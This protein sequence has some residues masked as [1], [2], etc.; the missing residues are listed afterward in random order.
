VR[1]ERGAVVKLDFAGAPQQAAPWREAWASKE[2]PLATGLVLIAI[3]WLL[4]W[5]WETAQSMVA[6]WI[7]SETFAHGFLIV[8]IAAWIV[9]RERHTIAALNPRPNF[10]VLPLLAAAGFG[11]L[12][13]HVAGTGVLQ[14]FGL[15]IMIQLLA[16]TILGNQV[17]RALAFP[18]FFLLF[19][20]PFG[21]FLEPPLMDYTADFTAWAI[22]LTGI[23][24]FRDGRFL[25]LPSG[26]W[27]I[28]EACSGL[29]YL[30]AS[31][32]VG[33][34]YAYLT[35]RTAKRRVLF[36]VAS[37]I[38]PIVANWLR[39]FTVIMIG[40]FSGMKYAVG[41]D[42][43]IYGWFFFGVVIMLLFWIGSYWREDLAEHGT[44]PGAAAPALR[45]DSAPGA[46]LLA[47]LAAA[48]I[49]AV[50][51]AVA[52]R[53][54]GTGPYPPLNLQAP[55]PAGGWQPVDGRFTDWTPRI[56]N[57]RIQI[58]QTYAR[59]A[60]RAGIN[61]S[62][63]RNQNKESQLITSQNLTLRSTEANWA[64]SG[65]TRR[66]PVINNEEMPTIEAQLRSA[67]TRLLVWRWYWVDGQYTVNP[68]WAKFLQAKSTLLGRGDDGAIVVVYTDLDVD[69]EQAASRLLEFSNTMLPGITGSLDHAH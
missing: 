51:P 42:H 53:L 17:V 52:S 18:L 10:F 54:E 57:P 69:R 29:R 5:Y 36:V 49:V 58:D 46:I 35:Y 48:A 55:P 12:I 26:S 25:T 56:S 41:V 23:P 33:F 7:R 39:A 4:A 13:G 20:V 15:V 3:F 31:L 14:Q 32:T 1:H 66:T 22:R 24:I 38:V 43:I 65:E 44:E 27:S 8:P 34:L 45:G 21:E 61:L 67:S 68:Y 37:L 63:Y 11:W 50:W 2:W 40:H 16:W 62:Y 60:A 9:W 19:A 64:S 59:D 30:I 28:V 6:I 47:T